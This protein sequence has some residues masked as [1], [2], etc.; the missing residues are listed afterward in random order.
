VI[1]DEMETDRDSIAA[2][3]AVVQRF[4]PDY[5]MEKVL[6]AWLHKE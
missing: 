1:A 3:F 2:V 4:A 5:D 6:D